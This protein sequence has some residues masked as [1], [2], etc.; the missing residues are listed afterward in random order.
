MEDFSEEKT[1]LCAM[2]RIFGYEPRIASALLDCFGSAASVFRQD[3]K[4]ISEVLGPWSGH[5]DKICARSLDMAAAELEEA[6]RLGVEFVGRGETGYP[7]LLAECED[8]PAGLYVR[9]AAPA[10]CMATPRPFIAIVGTR[11]ISP[12]GK[13]WCIRIVDA[14][15]RTGENPV[16]VSGLA[17][18]TD[19]TAHLA[20]LENGLDTIAVMAT[21][22]DTVYPAAHRPAARQIEE[23]PGSALVTDY[24]LHTQAIPVNFVRRNR[25]IAGM[26][27]AT[28]LIES[29]LKGGG[30]ITANQAFSYDRDVFVLPGRADDPMSAGCN[31]LIRTGCATPITSE[32]NLMESLGFSLKKAEGGKRKLSEYYKGVLDSCRTEQMSRI[33]LAIKK[34]R[35]ISMDELSETCGIGYSTVAG[36]CGIL[37]TDGFIDIDL[38]Q[39]CTINRKK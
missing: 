27:R 21:G 7:V 2:N 32:R 11:D 1:C 6:R 24:P 22:A 18:G 10:A 9:S 26:C 16:I 39:R 15:A 38:M 25:I 12:Y 20:A 19:I 34:N 17:Y 5:A 37:E 3:R 29:R 28:I 33:L 8:A 4:T 36:L 14:L 13:E 35:R 31:Y 23:K 30:I